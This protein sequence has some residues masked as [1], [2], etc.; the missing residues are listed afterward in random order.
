MGKRR[1]AR[2][3]ALEVLY[4]IEIAEDELEF[5]LSNHFASKSVDDET[6]AFAESLVKQVMNH[7]GDIDKLISDT[8][9]NWDLV[10]IAIIDKNILRFAIA[11]LLYFPDIP[12]KVTIDEAI[13]VAKKYSTPDSGRFV[14]GILDK[15]AKSHPEAATKAGN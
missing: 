1:R 9:K 5:V 10:R 11:E 7:L 6:R 2:E 15:I 4:R 3:F 8:A 14:N 13:E 12:M